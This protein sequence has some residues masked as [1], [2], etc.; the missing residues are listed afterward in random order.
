MESNFIRPLSHDEKREV[1]E[2]GTESILTKFLKELSKKQSE[3]D[4]KSRPFDGYSARMDFES[5]MRNKIDEL[6]ATVD[7]ELK[8]RTIDFGN[9]DTYGELS[10][11]EFTEK[12]PCAVNRTV[13]GIKQEVVIGQRYKFKC[14]Q[15]GNR[16]S[17]V[18][19]NEK[20]DEFDK[21]LN[22]VFLKNDIISEKETK[23]KKSEI[24]SDETI[25]EKPKK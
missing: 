5:R 14:K 6:S 20:I 13:H 4:K 10:R 22:N 21:W 24:T 17:I 12:T 3:Y 18:V 23:T 2:L 15:R 7:E 19:D 1:I 8:D 9:L 25:S 11:F 16:I